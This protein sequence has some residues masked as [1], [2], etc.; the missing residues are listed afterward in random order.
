MKCHR[1]M[2]LYGCKRKNKSLQMLKRPLYIQNKTIDPI[3]LLA[4]SI[5]ESVG[6]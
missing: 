1:S 3:E 4:Q 5:M 6:I 2:I